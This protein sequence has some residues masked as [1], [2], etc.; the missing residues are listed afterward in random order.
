MSTVI[1]LTKFRNTRPNSPHTPFD[2]ANFSI[3]KEKDQLWSD[4]IVKVWDQTDNLVTGIINDLP[5]EIYGDCIV[6]MV[7]RIQVA[8]HELIGMLEEYELCVETDTEY[9]SVR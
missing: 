6:Q 2:R 3:K 8:F 5:Y 9:L 1:D 4:A 7:D